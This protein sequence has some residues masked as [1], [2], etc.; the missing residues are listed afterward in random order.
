MAVP[1]QITFDI[2]TL[3]LENELLW[4]GPECIRLR[5]KTFA[6]LRALA[7]RS[8]QLATKNDLLNA[9]WQDCNVGEEALKHCVAEIRRALGDDAETPRF[10]ETV[11]RRGYR[12]LPETNIQRTADKVRQPS[13]SDSNRQPVA[14]M[15][16][17]VGRNAELASL[18]HFLGKAMSGTRQI[19]FVAGDQGIGKT[20][21]VDAFLDTLNPERQ[22]PLHEETKDTRPWIARGHCIQSHGAGE[23]YMPIMEAFT[24]LG[25][26]PERKHIVPLLQRYAP[27]WLAQMQ[28][29]VSPALLQRLQRVTAG[30]TRERMM[31]EMAEAFDAITSEHPMILI[32]EDLHWSDYSTLDLISYW[33]QRRNPS[34]L[35]LIATCRPADGAVNGNPLETIK[36]KLQEH[37][38]CHEL[39][40][41]FLDETA[42]HEYLQRRFRGHQFPKEIA[43]WIRQRTAGNPLF[44]VNVLDHLVAQ[45]VI[46]LRDS[47]WILDI[48]LTEAAQLVPPTIQQIIERQL[49]RCSQQEQQ[50]LKAASVEGE[51]FSA[52]GTAA[53]LG[54]KIDGVTASLRTLE[55]R[56]QFLQTGHLSSKDK[57]RYRFT[58]SLYQTVCYQLL[59]E[60]LRTHYHG[61]IA[62]HIEQAHRTH[63]GEFAAQLAM[64]Y[65]RGQRPVQALE[66]YQKAAENANARYAGREA[67]DLASRGI[68]LLR[69]APKKSNLF[70]RELHFQNALGIALISTHSGGIEEVRQTFSRARDLFRRL[71]K[72]QQAGKQALLF[73]SIYGLWCYYWI[74]AQYATAYDL[75][76]QLLDLA[77]AKHDSSMLDQAHF[78]LACTLMDHGEFAG[79]LEHLGHSSNALSGCMAAVAQWNLGFP[80]QALKTIEQ[81]L[82]LVIKTGNP[83]PLLFAN[84]CR[85]QVHMERRE[86]KKVLEYA[87][88]SLDIAT[89][90]K[91]PE[92]LI[93]PVQCHI[94]WALAKLGQK[95]NGLEQ[96][97]QVLASVKTLGPSHL[98]SLHFC[99]LAELSMDTGRIQEG[100][101]AVN[102]AIEMVSSNGINYYDEELFRLKGE[103]LLKQLSQGKIVDPADPRFE[104]IGSNLEQAIKI[105][106]KQHAKSL[107]LRA[108]LS[109]TKLLRQQNRHAEAQKRLKRIY[110][111]F[112]E[113]F[114]TA[115]LQEA[116]LRDK[117]DFLN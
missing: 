25:R 42:I 111:W 95:N 82:A 100:L 24:E 15:H 44:I 9:V 68:E 90:K 41:P 56:H 64:H 114:Q 38:Q 37:G 12:F 88:K 113:G 110:D 4:M 73:S 32:L 47:R 79:A 69:K 39:L 101:A 34:R 57:S 85:A 84:L 20:S 45:G 58:H 61:K 21:L 43:P 28:S 49:E 22:P 75:A 76:Q 36:Q 83:E 107:E 87:R 91:L 93:A 86:Y 23:A 62:G 108:T 46:V 99:M 74:H 51:E 8:G 33:A 109:L 65:D 103:L 89:N 31:R 66:Y 71:S 117:Q 104:E 98:T 77:K 17:L 81:T 102:E 3:D 106:R 116:A 54:E 94:A 55:K 27:L 13:I 67:L 53:I 6:F 63:L 50:M 96:I 59:P 60:E 112:T 19:V 26:S 1:K 48:S 14:G 35:L 52:A 18:H 70:E 16:S 7:E 72:R 40:L 92:P 11:H 115:D 78:S 5:P 2:F 105:A 29:L 97:Q 10:I 30:A 80:D